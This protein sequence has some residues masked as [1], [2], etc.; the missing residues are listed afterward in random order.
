MK[1]R[2]ISSL[3]CC[4]LLVFSGSSFAQ[5]QDVITETGV[6][7]L[8]NSVDRATRKKNL[9]GM[10]APLASDVKIKLAVSASGSDKEQVVNLNKEQFTDV[11]RRT[12]RLRFTYTLDRKNTRVKIYDDN[13]T[14][15]VT[16]DLYETVTTARGKLRAVS[17]E[18]AVLT[19]RDG[20]LVF[21]SIESRMR[22][23]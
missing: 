2:L 14:A 12:L 4:L 3:F 17:S 15:M 5:S 19:L 6:L 10:I 9:A 20:K 16:S 7:A 22:F 1:P 23:Y 11:T 18:T 21:I 13:K 8:M